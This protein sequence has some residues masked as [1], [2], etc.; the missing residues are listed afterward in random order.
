V[1]SNVG[2]TVGAPDGE[3]V[4]AGVAIPDL[5]VGSKVGDT[6]GVTVGRVLGLFVGAFAKYVGICVGRFDTIVSSS[7]SP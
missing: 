1:G 5:Y 7:S 3:F 6:V 2:D 4:G